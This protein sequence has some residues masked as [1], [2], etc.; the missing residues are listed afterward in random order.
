[1]QRGRWW[2]K[3]HINCAQ[4]YYVSSW[5]WRLFSWSTDLSFSCS[6]LS[7]SCSSMIFWFSLHKCPWHGHQHCAL[8]HVW[9]EKC[10]WSYSCRSVMR[11]S[12]ES[13]SSLRLLIC[14]WW[15]SLWD[16]ICFS[17]ASWPNR[18]KQLQSRLSE[19]EHTCAEQL[20]VTL[21]W[22]HWQTGSHSPSVRLSLKGDKKMCVS[23]FSCT[24]F[25]IGTFTLSLLRWPH[26]CH[27]CA[28]NDLAAGTY[29][30]LMGLTLS[31]YPYN[32]LIERVHVFFQLSLLL[33][34]GSKGF[35]QRLDLHFILNT[36]H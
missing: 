35:R 23:F 19:A 11:F 24:S 17:T 34:Y 36:H 12:L 4:R 18:C 2:T 1:M 21:P 32:F 25:Q 27:W 6:T 8:N 16:W 5:S 31:F 10:V 20:S 13:S 15:L 9:T 3:S 30:V 14:F 33:L 29:W 22:L 7:L 26:N 28:W